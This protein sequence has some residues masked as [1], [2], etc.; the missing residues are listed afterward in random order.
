MQIAIRRQT[1]QRGNAIIEFSLVISFLVMLLMGT[2]SI[3]MTLTKSVQAGVVARDAGAMFM[4][5][6]DFTLTGNKDIL[7]RLANGMGMTA[8]GGKG[9]V[10][11]T[12]VMFV[13]ATECANGGLSTGACPNYNRPVVIKRMTVG[14]T[15]LYTTTF[16]NPSA[17]IIQSDGTLSTTDYLTNTTARADNFS[18]VMTLNAG[19]F[20]YI[21]EAY[22]N[23][24]EIDMPGFRDNTYVYQ[25]NIF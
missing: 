7:I 8:S 15:A 5:Y 25:R 3:G 21:S 22:F 10:I 16:G 6:V 23:T 11:M 24:P 9:V 19:E 14:N 12:Q 20:A 13:G 17:S 4:R 18:S 2:F 1:R